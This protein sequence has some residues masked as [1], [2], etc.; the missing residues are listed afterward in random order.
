M[1]RYGHCCAEIAKHDTGEELFRAAP[2]PLCEDSVAFLSGPTVAL[3]NGRYKVISHN[4]YYGTDS[5]G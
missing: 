2:I 4:I 5:M 3:L 1:L